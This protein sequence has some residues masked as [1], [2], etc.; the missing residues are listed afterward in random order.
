MSR[1]ACVEAP[2]AEMFFDSTRYGDALTY[3]VR[4][5]VI[6]ARAQLRRGRNPGVW[7]GVAYDEDGLVVNRTWSRHG[8]E[9]G[10]NA[11]RRRGE[12]PCR[13][14]KAAASRASNQRHQR[15]QAMAV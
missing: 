3:C 11:H 1:A 8:T 2:D 10:Y 13:A 9:S 5:P 12:T 15:R 4:C 14:C 7:G 6:D